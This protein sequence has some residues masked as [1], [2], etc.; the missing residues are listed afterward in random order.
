MDLKATLSFSLAIHRNNIIC[1][2]SDSI[3]RVFNADSFSHI[4]TLH[5]NII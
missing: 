1:G 3:I 5:S 2:S 4:T